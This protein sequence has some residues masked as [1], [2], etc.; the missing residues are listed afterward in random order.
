M[1]LTLCMLFRHLLIV[2]KINFIEKFFQEYDQCQTV[3]I[4]IR[5]DILSGLIWVQTVCSYQQTTLGEKGLTLS[6]H[7]TFALKKLSAL[8][9]CCIYSNA[10]QTRFDYGCEHY[11]SRS[12]CNL[13]WEHIVSNIGCPR[14]Q[15]YKRADEMIGDW[16]EELKKGRFTF[17][18][19]H[20]TKEQIIFYERAE[21]HKLKERTILS[22][23]RA[24]F[25]GN[26]QVMTSQ[27]IMK[28][29][30]G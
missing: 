17:E 29:A 20:N 25:P 11:E 2:F 16:R 4:Q 19:I 30:K 5:P 7:Y 6:C 15:A 23:K 24:L 21:K 9:I 10:L 13:V 22:F 1:L 8:Y 26:Y 14:T 27:V 18:R 28:E 3:W 12:D